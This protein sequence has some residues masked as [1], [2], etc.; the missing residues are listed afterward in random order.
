MGQ[1][2]LECAACFL[3]PYL[4]VGLGHGCRLPAIEFEGRA[5]SPSNTTSAAME[6]S[7]H[8]GGGGVRLSAYPHQLL[9]RGFWYR[10]VQERGLSSSS[11]SWRTRLGVLAAAPRSQP[12]HA[13]N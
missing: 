11:R 13:E 2:I 4:F 10:M 7:D 6:S 1:A 12:T 5:V 9:E 3:F 8:R